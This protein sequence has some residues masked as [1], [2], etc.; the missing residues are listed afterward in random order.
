MQIIKS[1]LYFGKQ[2][3][4]ICYSNRKTYN[5]NGILLWSRS[6]L[7]AQTVRSIVFTVTAAIFLQSTKEQHGI[8]TDLHF[9]NLTL[10]FCSL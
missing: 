8:Y 3:L 2:N 5:Q 9:C 6:S 4:R 10:R 1:L 7:M